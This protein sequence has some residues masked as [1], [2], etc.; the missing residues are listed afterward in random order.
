MINH[1]S[2]FSPRNVYVHVL[3]CSVGCVLTGAAC[4]GDGDGGGGDGGGAGY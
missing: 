2:H 4:G 3:H 1:N